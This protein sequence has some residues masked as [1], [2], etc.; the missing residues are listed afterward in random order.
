MLRTGGILEK[1]VK[2]FTFFPDFDCNNAFIDLINYTDGCDPGEGLYENMVRYSKVYIAMSKEYNSPMVGDENTEIDDDRASGGD[3][4]SVDSDAGTGLTELAEDAMNDATSNVNGNADR[5][6]KLD[7]KTE[8]LGYCFYVKCNISMRRTADL[9]GVSGVLVHDI[10]YA[11]A[12]VLCLTL[13]N[14]SPFQQ[15]VRCFVHIQRV[16]S[17]SL[18]T[19][20]FSCC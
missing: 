1:F 15:E 10:A 12:N 19:Q 11:W 18:G 2:D 17:K 3:D 6:W 20:I 16:S 14:S 7:W 13:K 9:F 8:Y 5:H 4:I